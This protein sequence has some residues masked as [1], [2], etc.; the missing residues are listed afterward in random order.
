LNHEVRPEARSI[1]P[2][3]MRN[4]EVI[5]VWESVRAILEKPL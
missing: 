3:P 4:E 5:E 2:N 1:L